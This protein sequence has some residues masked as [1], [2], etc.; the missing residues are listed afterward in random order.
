MS[1]EVCLKRSV[2]SR[3]R[4]NNSNSAEITPSDT[5]THNNCRQFRNRQHPSQASARLPRYMYITCHHLKLLFYIC[6]RIRCAR[7]ARAPARYHS[8]RTGTVDI[9]FINF[10]W[11]SGGR[12]CL[13]TRMRILRISKF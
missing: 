4:K 10:N 11:Y 9:V 2:L 1:R 12:F 3:L 5:Q 6:T 13:R 7:D 8:N